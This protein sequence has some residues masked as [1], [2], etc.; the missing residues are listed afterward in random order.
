VRHSVVAVVQAL[1][2]RGILIDAS[3]VRL[4]LRIKTEEDW[5]CTSLVRCPASSRVERPGAVEDPRKTRGSLS[6]V[7]VRHRRGATDAG[8]LTCEC[9]SEAY[10]LGKNVAA[11]LHHDEV[12]DLLLRRL[13][14]R[15]ARR[16]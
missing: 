6:A 7:A 10:A 5:S 3:D 4:S 1:K 12:D 9:L 15:A 13:R 8:G 16:L 2:R 14:A 11:R